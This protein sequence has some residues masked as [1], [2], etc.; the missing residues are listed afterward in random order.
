[1][2]GRQP[3][4]DKTVVASPTRQEVRVYTAVKLVTVA[5]D[6]GVIT[7]IARQRVMAGSAIENLIGKA[8]VDG[9]RLLRL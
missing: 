5:A 2:N 8:S 9:H 7:H 3:V 6:Q 1:L 4:K